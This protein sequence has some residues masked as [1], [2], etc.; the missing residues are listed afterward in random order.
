M[1]NKTKY[2]YIAL[3][4]FIIGGIA[5]MALSNPNRSNVVIS[6]EPGIYD[7]YAKCI[8]ESGAKMFAAWWCPAC[9][10]QKEMF[11]TSVQYLPYQE[12]SLPN[13]K[14]QTIQCRQE[15]IEQYPTWQFSDG[16]R[17]TGVLDFDTLSELT[18]CLLTEDTI[19]EDAA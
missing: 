13:S 2:L 5:L 3:G 1:R 4:A 12:C 15:G 8:A 6:T 16:S 19:V 17:R 14:T 7:T 10:A 11:G 9:N 18:G